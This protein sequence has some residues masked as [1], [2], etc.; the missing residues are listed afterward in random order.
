MIRV[1]TRI[2]HPTDGVSMYRGFG[3]LGHLRRIMD[4]EFQQLNEF[5]WAVLSQAQILYMVRPATDHDVSLVKMAKKC[6]VPV[7]ID[8]DDHI[9]SIPKSN[10]SYP[11]YAKESH[12]NNIKWLIHNADMVTASV[13]YLRD[14][15]Q[16][17]R[18]TSSIV[19]VPN[20]FPSH[21]LYWDEPLIP[22]KPIIS[23]RGS[24]THDKDLSLAHEFYRATQKSL[25]NW[26]FHFFGEIDYQTQDIFEPGRAVIHPYSD[27]IDY[28]HEFHKSGTSLHLIPLEDNPF[29]RSKSN[30]AW[31]EASWAGAACIA[32]DFPEFQKPGIT[33][34]G[35]DS[36]TNPD[37]LVKLSRDYIRENLMIEDVNLTRVEIINHLIG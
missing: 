29:N 27:V 4:I 9:L 24:R 22:R 8:Y 11:F 21:M 18:F 28:M 1:L 3:P 19:T 37:D 25:V 2:P 13:D 15:L 34:F 20:A 14:E 12:Q 5:N 35:K 33:H 6:R 17:Y 23:W 36:P 10:P 26:Q 30:I 16:K 7:W 32:P 31:I